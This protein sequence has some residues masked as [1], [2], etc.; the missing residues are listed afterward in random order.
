METIYPQHNVMQEKKDESF[1]CAT[2][3][4]VTHLPPEL[5]RKGRFSDVWFVDLP[6]G[7]ER[8]A[9]FKIHIAKTKRDVAKYDLKE[10]VENSDGCTGAEI[11]GFITAAMYKAFHRNEEFTTEDIVESM[12]AT[13][14]LSK[15]KETEIRILR[16]WSKGRARIANLECD[17]D[18]PAWWSDEQPLV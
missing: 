15:T 16:E 12:K 4:T 1:F 11:E 18:K 5:L 14:F 13:P 10:L 7:R 17:Q 9:I 3:N 8:E 2:A 6:N